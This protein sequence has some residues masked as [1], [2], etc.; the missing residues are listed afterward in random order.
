MKYYQ[1]D[2]DA[3]DIP[4]SKFDRII[5]GLL[6][7]L[8]AFM[9]LAFGAVE[10]WSEAVLTTLVAAISICFFLK[11]IYERD[12]RPIWSWAYLPVALFIL[13]VVFQLL[14]LKTTLVS[15]LSP[16]TAAIKKELL[17]DLPNADALLKTMT[18]SFYPHATK[19]NLRLMLAVVAV[20]VVVLNIYRR[21]GQI[22]RLLA[23][24]ATIGGALAV[25]A[26]AQDVF[27]NGQ[28]Y[29]V[30]PTASGQ[31]YSGTFIC[32]SHYGQFMNL[33]IGSAFGLILV[34]TYEDLESRTMT[35]AAIYEYI[36]SPEARVTWIL[37][38]AIII[39]V[40]TVFISL[41][42]GGMI[43]MLIA[44]GFTTLIICSRR[45]L[46]GSGWIILL[47]ALGAFICILYLGFDAVYDRL[48]TM[49]GVDAY[50]GRWQIVKDI[51]IAWTRFPLFG[52][53]LG[54]H[55][56]VYPMFDRS[57]IPAL[58]T[59]AEN[60]YAQITEE[61]GLVGL[62]VFVVFGFI[63]WINY[64]RNIKYA[65][66]PIRLASYGLGFGLLA[67]MIH[68]LSDFGQHLP[69]NAMLSAIFCALLI[70]L[71]R[72]GNG[73]HPI[74]IPKIAGVHQGSI[75]LRTAALV[76]AAG[77]WAWVFLSAHNAR[78]AEAHWERALVAEQDILEKDQQVT[79]EEY[80]D[81]ISNAA[82]AADYEPDNI[83]YRH[84]LNFYH[85]QSISRNT[86]PNTGSVIIPEQAMGYVHRIVDE[87]HQARVLCP[88]Y[89]ATCCVVGQLERFVLKDPN[90]A[91]L[92]RKGFQL[93]PCDPTACFIAGL[94]DV[95]E[96]DIE[97][98]FAKFE[99]AVR[100][101]S[102]LFAEV[103]RIYVD[104]LGRPDLALM[105]ADQNID[106]LNHVADTLDRNQAYS[107]F[108]D[109]PWQGDSF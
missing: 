88:T 17:S 2:L 57:S 18:F 64:A 40:A 5:E 79:N 68:S 92:I 91:E 62:A 105:I 19:H 87:F 3:M 23:A 86:D 90:G 78:V 109:E 37:I 107:D 9:P 56:V 30:V 66:T 51:S 104:R 60:E 75:V 71:G 76:C 10:A 35:P 48:A 100:L 46:K 54:T 43:S 27:G 101:S 22:K 52:T 25:L 63:V 38:G 47:A 44:A 65:D 32:H 34:K 102:R 49:Q 53:G 39:G 69:A 29:W 94:L 98:S 84:W 89:G 99:R 96:G 97:A 72:I 6:I 74:A 8:L 15:T 67:V 83:K 26:L 61:T 95:E 103:A 77:L 13:V 50:K 55:E 85:W 7:V 4:W 20:F 93:A 73:S 58:A 41:T 45:S 59:H 1:T 42:R 81:L 36:I 16:S 108:L 82:A 31:A 33:S 28:I 14:P 21:E 12:V 24:I 11:L 106:W 80:I 70:V